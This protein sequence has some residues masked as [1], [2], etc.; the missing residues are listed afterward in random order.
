M[1]PSDAIHWMEPDLLPALDRESIVPLYRQIYEHLREAILA[2][3]L[4]GIDAPAARAHLGRAAR[5][6]TAARSCTPT[7]SS[8]PTGLIEQRVG[9]GSRVVPQLRGGQPERA[10]RRAVVGDVCRPGVSASFP[11]CWAS[12]LPSPKP[13]ASRSSKASRPTSRR[14]SASSRNRLRA[15]RAIRASSSRTAIPKDTSRCARRS[16]RG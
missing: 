5:R 2:G 1:E 8:S 16:P 13:G 15:S 10:A 9:S 3:T 12:W 11:T 6:S 7:A 4:P 14:R